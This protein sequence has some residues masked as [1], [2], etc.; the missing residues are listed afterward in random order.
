[1]A[2]YKYVKEQPEDGWCNTVHKW[3]DGEFSVQYA[4]EQWDG[5]TAKHYQE[6]HNRHREF[7][8]VRY[9]DNDEADKVIKKLMRHF[10]IKFT[11]DYKLRSWGKAHY[12][13]NFIEFPKHNVSLG[14]ICHEIAHLLSYKKH[15]KKG[16]GHGKKFQRQSDVVCNW[17]KRYLPIKGKE[18]SDGKANEEVQGDS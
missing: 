6:E 18:S 4:V 14:M 2:R 1:M 12:F 3:K 13:W 5:F 16:R 10:K 15:G 9:K 17:A 8:D 11:W 7:Y